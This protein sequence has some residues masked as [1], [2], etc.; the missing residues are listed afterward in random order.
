[1]YA[2]HLAGDWQAASAGYRRRGC[3]YES[4]LACY[5]G[6]D[7]Q[8]LKEAVRDLDQLDARPAARRLRARLASLGARRIPRGPNAPR[9]AHP[10]DLTPREEDVLRAL[11]MG[12]SNAQIG[13]RLFVSAKTVDH[14]VSSILA[15]LEAPS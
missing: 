1:P 10:F 14:H 8:A 13:K 15:K 12:L 6:D 11:A 7:Q 5:D 2:E 3:V 9:K 4:A